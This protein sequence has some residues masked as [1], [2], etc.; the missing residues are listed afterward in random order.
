MSTNGADDSLPPPLSA[1]EFDDM[2]R[3]DEREF[4]I[5]MRLRDIEAWVAEIKSRAEDI[6]NT[7]D[8]RPNRR[9]R[10]TYIS[11]VTDLDTLLASCASIRRTFDSGQFELALSGMRTIEGNVRAINARVTDPLLEIGR[12]VSAGARRGGKQDP[13]RDMRM[14]REFNAR[15]GRSHGLSPTAIKKQIGKAE[16]LSDRAAV[17]AIDRG[18]KKIMQKPANCTD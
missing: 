2:V 15:L 11:K 9:E 12:K 7:P 5:P 14:A 10:G 8:V 16:G 13:D 18:L 4:E 3:R 17:Y 1:E 6:R